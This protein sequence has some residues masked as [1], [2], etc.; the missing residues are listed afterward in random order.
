M[1]TAKSPP[2][3]ALVI[4]A[5]CF[6]LLLAA[7]A[8]AQETPAAAPASEIDWPGLYAE[9]GQYF[10]GYLRYDTS[11]PPGDV[12]SAIGF[13]KKILDIEEIKYETFSAAPGKVNLVARLPGPAGVKPLL[14]MSHADVVPVVA[15]DWSHP[16]FRAE[17]QDG[18]VWGRGTIDNKAHGIMALMTLVTLKRGNVALR[19]GVEMMVNADEEIGGALGAKW[20][21]EN[22]WDAIDPA[23]AINEGGGGTQNWLGSQGVTFRVAVAEKGPLWLKLVARGHSGHGS[24][25]NPDNPNLILIDALHRILAEQQPAQ[26]VP[27]MDRAFGDVAPRMAFPGSFELAHLGLPF[28]LRI[29]SN[30]PLADYAVQALLRDTISPTM[31]VSGIKAN[32][33]P[34]KAEATLDCRLLPGTGVDAFIEKIRNLIDDSRITIEVLQKPDGGDWISPTEGPAWDAINEVVRQDFPGALVVPSMMAGGTDSR[35]L[36]NKHVPAYGFVPIVLDRGE[37]RRI[38]GVDERL[39]TENLNHGI[40]A[41]YDLTLKLC[42][43]QP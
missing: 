1:P 41:T 38:H 29:A 21:V 28:M 15:A 36:R 25:P 5:S 3:L 34:A 2:S 9:A 40:K 10:R 33:I 19:R 35:F 16:P 42:A 4:F 43:K 30:G 18:Y 12:N 8:V 27:V 26:V 22:H 31:L 11:N 17:Y 23:F 39:S 32:V 13:L 7:A 14:L 37:Y 24:E 20:M 6:P